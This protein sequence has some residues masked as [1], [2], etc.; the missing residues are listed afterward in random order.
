MSEVFKGILIPFIGT[1]FGACFVLFMKKNLSTLVEKALDGFAAGVMVAASIWSL[2]IPAINQS[3]YMGR[4]SFIPA[5]IGFWI[6]ILFLLLLDHLIPHMHQHSS[7]DEGPKS[8]FTRVTKLVLAVTLHNI[9]EGMAVGVVYAGW[10]AGNKDISIMSA[11]VLS[12]G[13]AIQNIPEGAVISMPLHAQGVPKKK[14][15]AY[16]VL[17]GAVEPAGA[18]ITIVLSGII[19]PALPYLLSFAA[20]AMLYV[21]IEELIPEMSQ[22]KHTDISTIMF[23]VGFSLMMVLDVAL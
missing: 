2:L 3:E 7:E 23:A 19:I 8:N 4:L 6:G 18:I 22:G 14:A 16:G 9:P 20:G 1:T 17:S 15:F 21:V 5:A 11:L 12:I 10:I 13:I